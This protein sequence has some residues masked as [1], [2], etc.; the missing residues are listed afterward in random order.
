MTSSLWAQKLDQQPAVTYDM[1]KDGK[2]R[3]SNQEKQG[4]HKWCTATT[5]MASRGTKRML[6]YDMGKDGEER[7][8]NQEKQGKHKWCTENTIMA[9]RRTKRMLFYGAFSHVFPYH[10]S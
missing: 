6:F 3:F 7:F 2:E 5:I 10:M 8:C 4:K 9:S 1:G